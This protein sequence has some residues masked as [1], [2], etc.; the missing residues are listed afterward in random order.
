MV[1]TMYS[2]THA[3]HAA[4][5]T[6]YGMPPEYWRMEPDMVDQY[7]AY[8]GPAN[9]VDYN[10]VISTPTDYT[11]PTDDELKA[12]K[13]EA[14]ELG[15]E[16]WKDAIKQYQTWLKFNPLSATP[17]FGTKFN[18]IFGSYADEYMTIM[19]ALWRDDLQLLCQSACAWLNANEYA[20][21]GYTTDEVILHFQTTGMEDPAGLTAA[22]TAMNTASVTVV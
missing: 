13:Q 2:M 6:C 17:P 12:A 4:E 21:F 5:V 14:E 22:F 10:N 8:V 9:P 11:Y 1:S 7:V 16:V 19:Q 3:S 18:E 20:D 15:N